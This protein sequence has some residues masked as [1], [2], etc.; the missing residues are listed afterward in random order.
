[1]A[2]GQ[3]VLSRTLDV[4]CAEPGRGLARRRRSGPR[5]RPRPPAPRRARAAPVHA[6]AGLE[7]NT[8]P[9]A[10]LVLSCS[11]HRATQLL[12]GRPR[13]RA[14]GRRA[15]GARVRA[16]HRRAVPQAR[17]RRSSRCRSR[18]AWRSGTGCRPGSPTA[19]PSCRPRGSGSCCARWVIQTDPAGADRTPPAGRSRRRRSTTGDATTGWSTCNLLGANAPQAQAALANIRR[20]RRPVQRRRHPHRRQAPP[21]RRPRPALRPHRPPLRRRPALPARL[22]LPPRT[23]RPV[24]RRPHRPRPARRRA[25]HHRRA[26]RARRPR[27]PRA[28]PARR[29]PALRTGPARGVRRRRRRPGRE[30][31]PGRTTAA[32]RPR[33]RPR[34][35]PAPGELTAGPAPATAPRRPPATR[36]ATRRP[37]RRPDRRAV[38]RPARRPDPPASRPA[39][40]APTG[41]PRACAGSSP[42]AARGAS[43][44]AAAPARSAATW[45]TTSPGRSARPAP[46]TSARSAGATTGSSRP[47]GASCAPATPACAGP[48][49]A[50]RTWTSP[51]QHQP[52]QPRR[53]TRCRRS[54]RPQPGCPT[55]TAGSS[56]PATRIWDDPAA[57]ELR[58]IDLEPDD[59]DPHPTR[60]TSWTTD[61]DDP[62]AWLDLPPHPRTVDAAAAGTTACRHARR[63]P[64]HA[65]DLAISLAVRQDLGREHDEA[66]I[67]EF[68]DRVGPAIDARVEQRLA[69]PAQARAPRDQL[70]NVSSALA[71]GSLGVGIPISAIVAR[72]DGERRFAGLIALL[73][74]WTG[75]AAVN[76]AHN[77]SALSDG[78]LRSVSPAAAPP[79]P[80]RARCAGCRPS[81][82]RAAARPCSPRRR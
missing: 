10:A 59:V 35:A 9:Q 22:R 28:R 30:Q 77:R 64:H 27:T 69:A 31:R 46:A 19:T 67:G 40:P 34:R 21:R 57:H 55:T 7:L 2:A 53:A 48:A 15:G 62:Y 75:I 5:R 44:P 1:M 56:T 39:P 42:S 52:P 81:T 26:R 60:D 25:R 50:G 68:L 20:Q 23:T 16:A 47:A 63:P 65:D 82:S 36:S 3:Q 76:V 80:C 18:S 13:A 45:T 78:G 4:R 71:F 66:V 38:H 17:R 70:D 6:A 12:V 54:S 58:A 51:S 74:A 32:Q 11:E 33:R 43:G 72:R 41:F 37:A 49:P 24:R 61:L 73:V 29:A 14:A 79:S 8:V